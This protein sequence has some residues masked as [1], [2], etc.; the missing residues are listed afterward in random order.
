MKA[1]DVRW[2]NQS[3]AHMAHM[4]T[5]TRLDRADDYLFKAIH[6]QSW[7]RKLQFIGLAMEMIDTVADSWPPPKV[8]D[9]VGQ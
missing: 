2:E 1:S 5:R 7:K 6:E 8:D 4:R 9:R 3:N